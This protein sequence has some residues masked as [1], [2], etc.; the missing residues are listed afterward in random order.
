M[1]SLTRTSWPR[2]TGEVVRCCGRSTASGV[3]REQV[4]L[5]S[6]ARSIE[7]CGLI[8]PGSFVWI[9]RSIVGVGDRAKVC[10]DSAL[11]LSRSVRASQVWPSAIRFSR[12]RHSS[13]FFDLDVVML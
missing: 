11:T 2:E 6:S 13:I 4:S 12:A 5:F 3:R 8:D 7:A 10:S 1:P 9:N